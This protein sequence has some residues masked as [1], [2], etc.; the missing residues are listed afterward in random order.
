[1]PRQI[2]PLPDYDRYI[3][4][5]GRGERAVHRSEREQEY[6]DWLMEMAETD[7]GEGAEHRK[8]KQ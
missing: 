3:E 5:V 2:E 8:E 4:S 7:S 1:M 6:P